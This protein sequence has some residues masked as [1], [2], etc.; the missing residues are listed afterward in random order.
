MN[1][2]SR[3]S[4][5]IPPKPPVR[6]NTETRGLGS[7]RKSVL[8]K[9]IQTVT[10]DRETQHGTPENNFGTIAEFW[11]TYLGQTVTPKDVAVMMGLLKMARIKTGHNKIDNWV[12][13]IGYAACGAELEGLE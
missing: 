3:T 9:A 13:L 6:T 12:D 2:S 11:T 10:V 5:P 1:T 7:I 8:D 4:N